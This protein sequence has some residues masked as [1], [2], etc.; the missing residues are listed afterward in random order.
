[1][2][3]KHNLAL[4]LALLVVVAAAPG[5]G[6][7]NN[8][9][10]KNSLNDGVRAYNQGKFDLAQQKFEWALELSPENTNAQLFY[11]RAL[12][13]RFD[14]T[15]EEKLGL[16]T[17]KAYTN[18][19]AKNPDNAEAI[20]QSLAFSAKVYDDLARIVPDKRDMYE[21]TRRETLLKR[22]NMPSATAQTKADVHYTLGVGYWEKA[23]A[24][25]SHYVTKNQPIPPDIIEKVRPLAQKA[26]EHLQQAISVKPDY[27][28]AYFYEKLAY[29][30][31][32]YINS[33]QARKKEFQALA[34][35]SQDKYLEI[36]KQQQAAAQ[37]EAVPPPVAK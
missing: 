30:Q 36:Q 21:Q 13:A 4:L 11:A 32:V 27:A 12:I 25:D 2:N 22:A 3:R 17:I 33:D 20:D 23:Y 1:V 31:D 24:L 15:Q 29:L 14:Q 19:I 28:N 10:A 16:E 37:S 18:I 9:R 35:K 5:C 34:I 6:V 7:V 26:H 8:L